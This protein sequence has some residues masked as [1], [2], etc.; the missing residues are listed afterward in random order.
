MSSIDGKCP[1][2][3]NASLFHVIMDVERKAFA[4]LG[5]KSLEELRAEVRQFDGNPIPRGMATH[6]RRVLKV[7]AQKEA[8]ARANEE[9]RTERILHPVSPKK[10]R[11]DRGYDQGVAD[12]ERGHRHSLTDDWEQ[13][14]Y[15]DGFS[16]FER[17]TKF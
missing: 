16:G 3:Q 6:R 9:R 12:R 4:R 15:D 13:K 17:K 2:A 7:L 5:G 1:R 11:Y 14:G 8:E 10:V